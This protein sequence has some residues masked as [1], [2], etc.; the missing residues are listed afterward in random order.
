M[1]GSHLHRTPQQSIKPKVDPQ[2]QWF[3]TPLRT[4]LCPECW[5]SLTLCSPILTWPSPWRTFQSNE[6]TPSSPNTLLLTQTSCLHQGLLK[7]MY[8]LFPCQTCV[9]KP[10]GLLKQ[11]PIPEKPWN[12]ISMEFI[13]KL[14]LSSSYTLILVIVDHLSKQSLFILTNDTIMLSQLM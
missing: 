8:H 5:R 10:Y 1:G 6:D 3:T 14:P 13:E 4:H 9:T 11:L 7:I 12:Y 2:S